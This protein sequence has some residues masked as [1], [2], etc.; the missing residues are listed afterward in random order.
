MWTILGILLTSI[1]TVCAGVGALQDSQRAAKE[2]EEQIDN[3]R[4][5]LKKDISNEFSKRL[6]D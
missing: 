5:E 4:K 6:G 1:G 3:M 2:T